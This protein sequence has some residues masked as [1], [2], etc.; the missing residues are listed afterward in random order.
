MHTLLSRA[1]LATFLFASTSL[2]STAAHARIDASTRDGAAA[3]T[4]V[5]IAQ[6]DEPISAAPATCRK[7]SGKFHFQFEEAGIFDVL[8]QISLLTC[9]NFIVSEGVKSGKKELTIISRT[10]VTTDQAYS[11]FLSALEANNMALVPAGQYLKVVERKEA[12]KQALPMYEKLPDGSVGLIEQGDAISYNDAHVTFIYELR[13]ASKDAVQALVRNMLGKSGDVQVIGNNMLIITDSA[14]NVRRIM[15]ILDRVDVTGAG[16]RIHVVNIEFAEAAGVA[17]KLTDIFGA[18][19]VRGGAPKPKAPK[20][21]G[22]EGGGGDDIEDVSIEKIVADE[23]TN[24]LIIIASEKAFKHIRELI[25]VLDIPSELASTGAQIYVHPLNNADAQKVS[26]TLSSL[27]QGSAKAATSNA[28]GGA[29]DA[30]A[31]TNDPAQLFEG[32]VKITADEATNALVITSSARDYRALKKVIEQLDIRRPQVFVEAAILEVSLSQNRRFSIDAYSG[33]PITVPGIDG[34]GLGFLANEGGQG[35]ITSSAQLF[36]AQAL[37][38][39]LQATPG[40]LDATTATAALDSATGL[41]NLLGWVA[42][43]GPPVPGSQELFGFPVPSFGFVLNALQNNANVDVLSTPHIMTTDNEKAE[44][45]VGKRV[46]V[47]RGISPVGGVAGGLGFGGLQQ[48][49]YEDVKLKFTVTPH[50]NVDDDIRLEVEQEVS[51]LGENIA[52]G[53]GLTQPVITSR[54]AKTTIVVRDQQTMVMGGLIGTRKADT[55]R[56][57]PILGDIPIIGWLFKTWNDDEQKTNLILVLTPY[58]VR[59]RGDFEKIYDRKMAERKEFIEAFYGTAQD[60]N[61]YIDYDKKSGPLARLNKVLD[62]ELIKAENGGPGLPGETLITP[63]STLVPFSGGAG[64][65]GVESNGAVDDGATGDEGTNGNGAGDEGATDAPVDD[66]ASDPR[67]F[68]EPAPSEPAPEG[69]E[70]E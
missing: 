8:K 9:K 43:H 52:V 41:E 50:V 38:Q 3:D 35:L 51:D 20:A 15:A 30:K 21:D 69:G 55:E 24:K 29:K 11:A 31:K 66:G 27:A 26:S 45:S 19:S 67:S 1:L 49:A 37:F 14:S 12:A 36:A 28:R 60:Y 34:A 46:P 5:W 13:Y 53:N 10:P 17:Q 40:G 65:A 22:E 18:A 56:K 59:E 68:D 70:G 25:D 58:I 42:F 64:G 4:R 2:S 7:R 54:T 47:V 61:P 6:S 39:R 57:F 63:E 48:V 23:R 44:I 32:E 62:D 33:L 16:N